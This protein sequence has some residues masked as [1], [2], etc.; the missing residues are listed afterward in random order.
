MQSDVCFRIMA[1]HNKQFQ[2]EHVP[3]VLSNVK[4]NI[5][6]LLISKLTEHKRYISFISIDA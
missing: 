3:D 5:Y 2:P 1:N 4:Y 6:N